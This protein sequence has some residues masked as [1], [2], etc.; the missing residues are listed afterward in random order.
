M[1]TGFPIIITQA[2]VSAKIRKVSKLRRGVSYVSYVVD[3][4]SLGERKLVWRSD[5]EDAKAVARDVCQKIINGEQLALTLTNND[6]M[7][8]LRACDALKGVG[9][10][11]DTA[12]REYAD[13]LA[14]LS[15]KAGLA[16]VCRDWM[17][18]N[19]LELPRI[20]LSRAVM[21][22]RGRITPWTL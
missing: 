9:V 21:S 18:R 4:F 22:I 8:Y 17:K 16:E 13:G 12:C 19:T 7:A 15:G 3:Y 14:I 10:L 11:I 20:L 1:K 2:G 5:L 6:R